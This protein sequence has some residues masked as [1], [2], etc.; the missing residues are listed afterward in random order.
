M[1]KIQDGLQSALVAERKKRLCHVTWWEYK[2]NHPKGKDSIINDPYE[3]GLD[4][5]IIATAIAENWVDDLTFD[6][7]QIKQLSPMFGQFFTSRSKPDNFGQQVK[8]AGT[9]NDWQQLKNIVGGWHE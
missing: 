8:V 2:G 3:F 9:K 4:T 7:E 5:I 1:A 6:R